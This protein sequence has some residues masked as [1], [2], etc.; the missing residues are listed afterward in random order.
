VVT[1]RELVLCRRPRGRIE[2]DCFTLADRKLPALSPGQLL[3]RADCFSV[4]PS[5]IPRLS[6]DTYAPAFEL[7]VA[8]EA[9]AV[10]QVVESTADG[11]S[12]GDWSARWRPSWP[13]PGA[14]RW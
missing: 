12:A 13:R 6:A 7:G 2:P 1:A 3:I 9:R 14:R 5:M 8:V 11:W 10:G 4:D